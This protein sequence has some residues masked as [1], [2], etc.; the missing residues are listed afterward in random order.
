MDERRTEMTEA[1]EKAFR[2]I[3]EKYEIERVPNS[4]YLYQILVDGKWKTF[5]DKE[6]ETIA[7]FIK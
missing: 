2:E 7:L 6:L 1:E 3:A 5:G 4:D